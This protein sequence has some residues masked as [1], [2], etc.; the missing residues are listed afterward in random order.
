MVN[1]ADILIAFRRRI[2]IWEASFYRP[3]KHNIGS[4]PFRE[5]ICRM[6][7]IRGL[8]Y[9][10]SR[11]KKGGSFLVA[12]FPPVLH[13]ALDEPKMITMGMVMQPTTARIIRAVPEQCQR[14][15]FFGITF[16]NMQSRTIGTEFM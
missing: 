7:L 6:K 4:T 1:H 9:V 8:V 11:N 14:R 2:I 16:Q 12:V 13:S 10:R 3:V 5:T 15:S